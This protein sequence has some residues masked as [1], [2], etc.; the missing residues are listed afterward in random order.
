V[1]PSNATKTQ[2]TMAHQC[3]DLR[4]KMYPRYQSRSAGYYNIG[5]W[6]AERCAIVM[7][8]RL[9]FAGFDIIK[10]ISRAPRTH[11]RRMTVMEGSGDANS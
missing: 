4:S 5:D 11:N 7:V 10:Y 1:W 8:R 6:T 2:K 9:T 3:L